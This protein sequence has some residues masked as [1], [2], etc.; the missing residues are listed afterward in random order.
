MRRHDVSEENTP[1]REAATASE[2][3]TDGDDAAMASPDDDAL[4]KEGEK[5]LRAERRKAAKATAALREAETKLAEYARADQSETERMAQDLAE[6]D[7]RLASLETENMRLRVALR[8]GL[9]SDLVDRLKGES[10]DEIEEDAKALVSRMAPAP[11]ASDSPPAARP[12]VRTGG[13]PVPDEQT[14]EEEF[15]AGLL[16]HIGRPPQGARS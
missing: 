3:N 5:A 11:S 10:E 16:T 14:P 12:V 13:D 9:D 8:T 2:P 15:A 1:D 6:K 4:G 7:S